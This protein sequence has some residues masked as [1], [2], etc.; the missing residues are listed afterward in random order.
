MRG[1]VC[2]AAALRR[3]F[4]I[5]GSASSIVRHFDILS[6]EAFFKVT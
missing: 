1:Y 2:T 3:A 5:V 4:G 6:L